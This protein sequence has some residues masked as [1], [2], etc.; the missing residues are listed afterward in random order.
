MAKLSVISLTY[1]PGG[2]DLLG[3]SLRGCRGDWELI[4]VD[5]FAGRA[6]RGVA[7]AYLKN[8]CGLPLVWH[9][10]SKSKDRGTRGALAN[11]MNTGAMR[12]S[13]DYVVFTHDFTMPPRTLTV[14]WI[15]AFTHHGPQ[16][17][18]HGVAIELSAPA[19]D[20]TD[21]V[22]TWTVRPPLP[23]VRPWEPQV[24]ELFYLGVPMRFLERINGVD[25]RGDYSG[26][27]IMNALTTQARLVGY[28]FAVD[29]A[30]VLPM[31][32]HRAWETGD[33][34]DGLWK[35]KGHVTT[36]GEPLWT[37]P[38]HNRFRFTHATAK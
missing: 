26:P 38:S 21:D 14:D 7:S 2:I 9:G 32:D 1:R 10:P 22:R 17:L 27:T 12:A 25:E 6:E 19:P 8:E 11:A 37:V 30:L 15:A 29:P 35:I 4:L 18:V 20:L 28:D 13:G 34:F 5:D 16:T 24:F 36:A 23:P 31:V 33:E 3:E